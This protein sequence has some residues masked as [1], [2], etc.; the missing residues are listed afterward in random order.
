MSYHAGPPVWSPWE[1]VVAT[2]RRRPETLR[3]P[4]A[5]ITAALGL[6]GDPQLAVPDVH[7]ELLTAREVAGRLGVRT[8]WVTDKWNQ[9]LLP[10]YRLPGS[11]RLR[12]VWRDVVASLERNGGR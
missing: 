3:P 8:R 10:G 4:D 1:P 11:N 6:A 2:F 5:A 12:F 9:G 7:G